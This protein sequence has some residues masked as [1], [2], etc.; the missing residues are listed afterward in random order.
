MKKLA[1]IFLIVPLIIASCTRDPIADF[2]ISRNVVN[3]GETVFF[4]NN[5][6]DADYFEW[7]FGD[8]I[9]SSA[10][11]A[12]HFYNEPGTYYVTLYA[13]N[14]R[15]WVDEATRTLTVLPTTDLLVVVLEFFDE[16]PVMDASVLLYNTLDDWNAENNPLIEGFTDQYGEVLFTN[17]N[18]QRYYI[19]VWEAQHHNYW[20]AE[21]NVMWI[22]TH[23]LVPNE[24]NI[25]FAYVDYV[26]ET[27]KSSGERDRSM[28]RIKKLEK[29]DRRTYDMKME[30]IKE[31]IE[32]RKIADEVAK[33][34]SEKK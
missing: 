26:E 1:Y 24:E 32:E 11:D 34:I 29:V 23:I 8:G 17:L 13:Y 5:S 27:K 21:E 31:M 12:S 18:E 4:T 19:D 2:F 9:R 6:V 30:S 14:G 28:A 25:F 10:F 3:V 22:E 20:L 16:Y 7:D 15:N 33:R